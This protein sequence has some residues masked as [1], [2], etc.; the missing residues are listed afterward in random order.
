MDVGKLKSIIV[1]DRLDHLNSFVSLEI[2]ILR[3]EASNAMRIIKDFDIVI[4]ATDNYETRYIISD[5]CV[6][7]GKNYGSRLNL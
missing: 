1:R 3:L 5:A 6:I 7:P 4:D 2:I